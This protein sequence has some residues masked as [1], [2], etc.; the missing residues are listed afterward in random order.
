MTEKSDLIFVADLCGAT[1]EFQQIVTKMRAAVERLT[2]E[3]Q[4][5]KAGALDAKALDDLEHELI[6]SRRALAAIEQLV[7]AQVETLRRQLH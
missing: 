2:T 3:L 1:F 5:V 4:R 6:G 7:A